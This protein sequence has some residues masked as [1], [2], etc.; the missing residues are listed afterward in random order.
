MDS[1]Q[2]GG[3]SAGILA[4][5]AFCFQILRWLQGKR[6]HSL[7]CGKEI[8]VDVGDMTPKVHPEEKVEPK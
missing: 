8:E 2:V 3:M 4:V 6:I 1:A 7:C 5:L